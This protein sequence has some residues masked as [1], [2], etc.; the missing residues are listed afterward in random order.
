[1]IHYAVFKH[2]KKVIRPTL[3]KYILRYLQNFIPTLILQREKLVPQMFR[4]HWSIALT[5]A[6]INNKYSTITVTAIF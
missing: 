3:Q 2:H 1:M 6:A 5:H 4:T